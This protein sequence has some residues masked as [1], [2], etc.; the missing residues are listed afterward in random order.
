MKIKEQELARL[1]QIKEILQQK[2]AEEKN[3]T[4]ALQKELDAAKAQSNAVPPQL[5]TEISQI[6]AEV[7]RFAEKLAQLE[8]RV[9]KPS[10]TSAK[11][12]GSIA[13]GEKS[14]ETALSIE[15]K[16]DQIFTNLNQFLAKVRVA[17]KMPKTPVAEGQPAASAETKEPPA[18]RALK[19]SDLLRKQPVETESAPTR[20]PPESIPEEPAPPPVA[21]KPSD[22]L[23]RHQAAEAA[24]AAPEQEPV[25]PKSDKPKKITKP[26]KAKAPIEPAAETGEEEASEAEEGSEKK[27]KEAETPGGG[28]ITVPYPSDGSIVCPK[29]NK[30]NYQ[31]MQDPSNV[32]AYAPVKKF[33]RKF[34]CKSCRCN[35]RYKM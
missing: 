8:A 16:V 27:G 12:G 11:P 13:P 18:A 20:E 19:P 30:Q 32:V 14:S 23:K 22:I 10:T 17:S 1:A 3:R 26:V 24:E 9:L 6:R 31:E 29:C 5:L 35:W 25:A 33:G 34:Y 21:A 2:L 15:E 28:I 4:S 7:G